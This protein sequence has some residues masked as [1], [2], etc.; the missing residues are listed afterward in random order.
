MASY[1]ALFE[2]FDVVFL[3]NRDLF[4][5]F[6]RCFFYCI[7]KKLNKNI[8]IMYKNIEEMYRA[9]MYVLLKHKSFTLQTA[10]LK[11]TNAKIKNYF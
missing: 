6:S 9:L 7:K 3:K 5:C 8:F 11:K 1:I 2:F 4:Y 10:V